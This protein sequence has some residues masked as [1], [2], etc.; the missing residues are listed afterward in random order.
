MKKINPTIKGVI[1]A[2]TM[3]V[4]SLIVI[5]ITKSINGPYQYAVYSIYLA[6]ILWTLFA[7]KKTGSHSFKEFFS[8]GFKCFIVVTLLMVA[9]TFMLHHFNTQFRDEYIA[10]MK[11]DME[12][13]HD[14]TPLEIENM[15]TDTKSK[16]TTVITSGS[17]FIYLVL[18]A[19]ITAIG[20]GFLSEK[21]AN[22]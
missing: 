14:K 19:L 10:I 21:R 17:V 22:T 6:G 11:D 5:K 7:F 13:A 15:V 16:F 20:S 3:I 8:E 12:K 1:T 18:G 4:L 2:A 9:Y